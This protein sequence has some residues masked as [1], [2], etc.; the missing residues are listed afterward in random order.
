[1]PGDVVSNRPNLPQSIPE[2][3]VC[4][5]TWYRPDRTLPESI[6]EAE[7][8]R[9]TRYRPDGTLPEPIPEGHVGRVAADG[10]DR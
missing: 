9:G 8:C 1:M 7:V 2:A 5:V 6:P 10:D 3:H 4:R